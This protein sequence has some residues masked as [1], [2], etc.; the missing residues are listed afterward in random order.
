MNRWR[1]YLGCSQRLVQAERAIHDVGVRSTRRL[2]I[3]SM[4]CLCPSIQGDR[5]AQPALS[6][7]T[8]L[9]RKERLLGTLADVTVGVAPKLANQCSVGY[10]TP[11][12][13]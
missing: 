4:N 11:F 2:G 3:A 9:E 6:V 13:D 7:A 12:A 5:H 10:F 8:R 1:T